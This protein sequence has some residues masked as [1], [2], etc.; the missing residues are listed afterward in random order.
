[1]V[2]LFKEINKKIDGIIR[3]RMRFDNITSDFSDLSRKLFEE[4]SGIKVELRAI[5]G[6]K[7]RL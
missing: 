3:D 5:F 1:M 2:N 6:D 4:Y 7:M